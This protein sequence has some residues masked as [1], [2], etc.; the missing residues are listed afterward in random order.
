V[1]LILYKLHN[2]NSCALFIFEGKVLFL[3]KRKGGSVVDGPD[4]VCKLILL[5]WE[6]LRTRSESHLLRGILANQSLD[7]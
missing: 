5:S 1:Y 2:G 7:E 3:L 4:A 6:G